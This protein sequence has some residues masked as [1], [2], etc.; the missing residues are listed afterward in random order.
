MCTSFGLLVSYSSTTCMTRPST[1]ASLNPQPSAQPPPPIP[2]PPQRRLRRC[3]SRDPKAE[4]N[5]S[6]RQEALGEI[7]IADR[8]TLAFQNQGGFLLHKSRQTIKMKRSQVAAE[9]R[10]KKFND[11]IKDATFMLKLAVS[12]RSSVLPPLVLPPLV[13]PLALP[14]V[15]PLLTPDTPS[16]HRSSPTSATTSTPTNPNRSRLTRGTRRR[17]SLPQ[18]SNCSMRGDAGRRSTMSTSSNARRH[19]P[20]SGA[21]TFSAHETEREI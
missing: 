13:L 8:S 10:L 9:R 6:Q 20:I 21:T 18:P 5:V 1:F 15:L 4:Y 19:S 11:N 16:P 2:L 14:L 3:R 7:D 12:R 17:S